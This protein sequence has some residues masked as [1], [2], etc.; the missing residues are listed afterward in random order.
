[1]PLQNATFY[2]PLVSDDLPAM[3]DLIDRLHD[4]PLPMNEA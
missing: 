4:D 2:T 1:M 3:L